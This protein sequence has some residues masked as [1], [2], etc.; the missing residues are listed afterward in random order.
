[1]WKTLSSGRPWSGI[2][3]NRRKN[4]EVFEEEAT[5]SPI[6][7][8]NDDL[9]AY[10]AVKH[11]MTSQRHLEAVEADL[12][13]EKGDR[14]AL[15]DVMREIHPADTVQAST[16]IFC[17]AITRLTSVD[18]A[19]VLLVNET[20]A[21]VPVAISGSESFDVDGESTFST[22]GVTQLD[23]LTHEPVAFDFDPRQWPGNTPP[24]EIAHAEGFVRA[25]FLP[26][27][28][29]QQL[30]GALMLATKNPEVAATLRSRF[31]HFEELSSYA[32]TLFGAQARSFHHRSAT[33]AIIRDII[34]NHRFH[35][36]FQS[37]VDLADES[38][39]G[40][41]A[42]TR[43]DDGCRPDL[44][45]IEAHT[46]GMGS[47][48]E[49]AC[50]KAALDASNSLAPDNFVSFN[51]SPSAILDGSAARLLSGVTRRTVIEVTEHAQIDDYD[52]VIDA[53]DA[54]GNCVLAVD[55][56]G[57]SA[58]S[59]SHIL[60][61]RPEIIKLDISIVRDIDTNPARQAMAAGLC[62]FAAQSG[63]LIIAEAIETKAEA[64]FFRQLG[65]TLGRGGMLGQGYFFDR[66]AP[67]P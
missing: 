54:I 20:G 10:V 38:I 14:E 40:Y 12:S 30:I 18:A 24:G 37:F 6:F 22:E 16:A 43:F 57:V 65:A 45:I 5:I 11:D 3:V 64:E 66:P 31:S 1:M 23:R 9:I 13:R 56:A 67:L 63:T 8:D 59:L 2:L 33:R 4:G 39:V 50:A 52:A 26:I 61:L 34:D 41:E 17:E 25:V 32:G 55:D 29:E 47:E 49:A 7:D 46:V 36:V 53:I 62:H 28:W 48:L 58:A 21:L 44:R 27:Q 42:L 35:P 15:V 51:F 60:E 19:C